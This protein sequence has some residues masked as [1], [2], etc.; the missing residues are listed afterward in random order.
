MSQELCIVML[1]T[2]ISSQARQ[3]QSKAQ[4]LHFAYR[5]AVGTM[6]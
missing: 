4:V 3:W 1:E 2:A 6:R 5:G